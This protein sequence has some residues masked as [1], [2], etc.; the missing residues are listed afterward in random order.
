MSSLIPEYIIK[1]DLFLYGLEGATNLDEVKKRGFK[2][3]D[4]LSIMVHDG[5]GT[6]KFNATTADLPDAAN[7]MRDFLE[8]AFV[9]MILAHQAS[10]DATKGHPESK[11]A[12][13]HHRRK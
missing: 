1:R 11:P 9:G 2:A 10:L 3:G 7:S 5:K 4:T 12:R 13:S 6:V 8:T